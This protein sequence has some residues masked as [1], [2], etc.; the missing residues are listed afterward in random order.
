MSAPVSPRSFFI[1]FIIILF[2]F[3]VIQ[4]KAIPDVVT[5]ENLLEGIEELKEDHSLITRLLRRILAFF[6]AQPAEVK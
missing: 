4:V 2:L 3:V 1:L 5:H 6:A